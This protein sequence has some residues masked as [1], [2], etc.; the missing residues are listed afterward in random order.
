M[1]EIVMPR[2]SDTMEEGTILRWLKQDGEHVKRGE[3]LVEIETDKAAMTYE[4]DSEGTLQ[5]LAREGDTLAVGE[6]IARVGEASGDSSSNGA[7]AA[8]NAPLPW[9]HPTPP[10]HPLPGSR[11]RGCRRPACRDRAAPADTGSR[12]V[13]GSAPT[14]GSASRHLRS[15]GALRARGVSNLGTLVGSGPGGRIVKADV[16]VAGSNPPPLL[17]VSAIRHPRRS[18]VPIRSASPTAGL[19][20]PAQAAPSVEE[21]SSAKGETTTVELS[22]T[23]RTIARRMAESKATIPDFTLTA[24]IDMERCVDLRAEL[25]RL[26][27]AGDAR[28]KA[29]AP[30]GDARDKM[31]R[32]PTTT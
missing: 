27:R 25:K 30:A 18:R 24:D 19:N 20:A 2:L 22:R 7:P 32:Q 10:V 6:P 11:R 26:S 14:M 12:R 29:A 17:R 13:L 23:Q 8:R 21:V 31:S 5:T 15:P 1:S 28:D 3:E 9:T 4:S 16:E